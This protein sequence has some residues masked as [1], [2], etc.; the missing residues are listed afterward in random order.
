MLN[1]MKT[2]TACLKHCTPPPHGGVNVA[3]LRKM[4]MTPDM[5]V[6]F[7]VSVNPL[8]P[9]PEVHKALSNLDFS[10]YPD[11]ENLVLRETV[12]QKTGMRSEQIVFGNGTMELINLLAQAYLQSGDA[13]F[14]LSPTFSE[15]EMAAKRNNAE[16]VYLNA[17]DREGFYWNIANINRKIRLRKPKLVFLCNPN[18]PTGVYLSQDTVSALLEAVG[19]GHLILDEAYV[20]FVNERWDATTLL[21]NGNIVI[22]RSMTK[23][24][25][26]AALRL[27]YALCNPDVAYAILC[28]QPAW[29]VN[30]AAQAAGAAALS[31]KEYLPKARKLIM[32]SKDY[33]F[34]EIE[35]LGLRVW[36]A[37]ANFLLVK[38]GDAKTLR[39]ELLKNGICVRDCGSFGLPEFI[40][41]GVRTLP[42]C[43]HF[44][45][46]LKRTFNA[47]IG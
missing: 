25:A 41:V 38:V 46:V 5:V 47:L 8:G 28:R 1:V 6:D 21:Q 33:L 31:D 34:R 4:G 2:R 45:S 22:L 14:I 24:Y 29:S 20:S 42:E 27:G 39:F 9:P 43:M 30:A 10:S 23:D 17:L 26:L 37:A 12:A 36:P 16:V 15:Y 11:I 13:V 40:R 19:D 32:E 3:E 7:S 35:L 44:I 18:N